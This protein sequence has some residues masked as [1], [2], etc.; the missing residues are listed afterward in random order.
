MLSLSVDGI[1]IEGIDSSKPQTVFLAD[2][3]LLD[4]EDSV[5]L[6]D[7]DKQ[8]LYTEDINDNDVIKD[9]DDMSDE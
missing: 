2:F 4:S 6:D 7:H 5:L 3:I 1:V 8:L 9:L